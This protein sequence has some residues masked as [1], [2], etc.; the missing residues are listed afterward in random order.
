M[1]LG[2]FTLG[3]VLPITVMF[4]IINFTYAA[5]NEGDKAGDTKYGG[6]KQAPPKVDSTKQPSSSA[7]PSAN[8]RSATTFYSSS[9][10]PDSVF[11]NPF[12]FHFNPGKNYVQSSASS[13]ATN[14]RDTEPKAAK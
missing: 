1:K 3:L 5:E 4:C 9:P 10:F 14:A 11:P 8:L 13:P 2:K 12:A 7:A 6:A